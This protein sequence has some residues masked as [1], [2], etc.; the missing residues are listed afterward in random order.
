MYLNDI[1]FIYSSSS[2]KPA[3][4]KIL[5]SGNPGDILFNTFVEQS[6]Y[7]YDKIFPISNL[8]NFNITFLFPD[9]NLVD[10][11]NL[12]HSFTLKITEEKIQNSNTFLNSKYIKIQNYFTPLKI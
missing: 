10:F 9:G 1:E 5:L 12:N 7:Q 4:A 11:R 3:F 6:K 2:I 8:S